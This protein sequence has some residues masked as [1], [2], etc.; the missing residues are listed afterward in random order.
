MKWLTPRRLIGRF[1]YEERRFSERIIRRFLLFP[2]SCP[3]STGEHETRWME[4]AYV[5]QRHWQYRH[6]WWN[7]AWSDKAAF[8]RG[9]A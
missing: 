6:G 9:A 2:V 4:W 1:P 8:I 7:V 3:T 5:R